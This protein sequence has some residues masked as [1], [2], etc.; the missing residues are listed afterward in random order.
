MPLAVKR[1]TVADLPATVTL[2]DSMAMLEGHHLSS[3]EEI[4][5]GARVSRDGKP[6]PQA[7]DLQG[8]GRAINPRETSTQSILIDKSAK[9]VLLNYG[10]GQS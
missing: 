10:K 5:V 1:L 8:L 4:I 3:H 6:M 7:G 9:L 2:D